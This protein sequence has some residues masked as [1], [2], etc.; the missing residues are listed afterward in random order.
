M[1]NCDQ[2]DKTYTR[3]ANLNKHKLAIHDGIRF[4]CAHCD[5]IYSSK[6]YLNLHVNRM[7]F[8]TPK[9]NP[10]PSLSST[11]KQTESRV[12]E[13]DTDIDLIINDHISAIKQYKTKRERSVIINLNLLQ[14]RLQK[15]VLMKIYRYHKCAFKINASPGF[16]LANKVSKKFK[17]F[18]ASSGSKDTILP[19][20]VTIVSKSDLEDFVDLLLSIDIVDILKT[21]L[22]SSQWQVKT[23]TNLSL[24]TFVLQGHALSPR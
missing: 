7:H 5:K 18:H 15:R 10:L 2:C 1:Y 14:N 21:K 24:Y 8:Q 4:S 11:S 23:L 16:V 22:P 17:Y 9:T 6:A 3:K 19:Y 20:P 13:N 12:V